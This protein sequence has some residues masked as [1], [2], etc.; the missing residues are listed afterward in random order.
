MFFDVV[1]IFVS[2]ALCDLFWFHSDCNANWRLN[3]FFSCVLTFF[4]PHVD[5]ECHVLLLQFFPH[6]LALR[7]LCITSF[8]MGQTPVT[9]VDLWIQPVS[10]SN[11]FYAKPPTKGL[12]TR[13]DKSLLID[14]KLMVSLFYLNSA[15]HRNM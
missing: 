10:V 1:E 13:T 9:V 3:F 4:S 14:K 5:T 6:H 7:L 15:F 11:M 8:T 12:E 2:P